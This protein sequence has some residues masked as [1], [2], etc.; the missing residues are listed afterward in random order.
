MGWVVFPP[1][2][3]MGER[4]EQTSRVIAVDER[5]TNACFEKSI[6]AEIGGAGRWTINHPKAVG[7]AP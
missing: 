2:F 3:G 7:T 5:P 6:S 1:R 4:Q